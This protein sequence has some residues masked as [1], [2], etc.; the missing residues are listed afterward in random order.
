MIT[1]LEALRA[2]RLREPAKLPSFV[3]GTRVPDKDARV[4]ATALLSND[5]FVIY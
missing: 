2:G 1:T 5:G 4:A 3:L